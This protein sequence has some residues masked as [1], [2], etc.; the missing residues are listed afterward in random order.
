MGVREARARR[1]RH[2]R[3]ERHNHES[4]FQQQ[5][6]TLHSAANSVPHMHIL[7]GNIQVINRPDLHLLPG[8]EEHGAVV[9]ELRLLTVIRGKFQLKHTS[10]LGCIQERTRKEGAQWA[11][12]FRAVRYWH[13]LSG[14]SQAAARQLQFYGHEVESIPELT[15]TFSTAPEREP[16]TFVTSASMPS[17]QFLRFSQIRV[18][19]PGHTHAI[20]FPSNEG[21]PE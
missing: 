12:T 7:R 1:E 16:N 15:P 4:V 14:C 21:A 8:A 10:G 17:D 20:G 19:M 18:K 3:M 11:R 9:E 6:Q 5:L 13:A 2:D